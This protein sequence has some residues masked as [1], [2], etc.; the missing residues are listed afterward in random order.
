MIDAV[1]LLIQVSLLPARDCNTK[2][3]IV[4]KLKEVMTTKRIIEGSL[5]HS[6]V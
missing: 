2:S 1:L 4:A 6:A 3:Q 5:L